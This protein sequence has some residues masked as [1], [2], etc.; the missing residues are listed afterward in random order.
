MRPSSSGLRVAV[1]VLVVGLLAACGGDD[2]DAVP[3]ED[4]GGTED[5][6]DESPPDTEDTT[7]DTTD[8][9]AA[10]AA[11]ACSLLDADFLDDTFE[12]VDGMFGD[13]YEFQEPLQQSPTA[14]CSWKDGPSGQSIELTVEDAAT[15]E[16]DDHSGRIRD[17]DFEPDVE[18]TDGPGT[19]SV[20]LFDTEFAGEQF[21]P[22]YYGYFF[23]E[24][25]AAVFI[26]LSGLDIGAD[27]LRTLAD[28][29]D[30]RLLAG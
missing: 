18:P 6:V 29:A 26:E 25:E 2:T 13:P 19:K 17:P 4:T 10:P 11:D 20:L 8:A 3:V 9:G 12:G 28:E 21:E 30:A 23:V 1:L 22:Y 7:D 5:T 15:A 14:F 24:G 16:V 27:A